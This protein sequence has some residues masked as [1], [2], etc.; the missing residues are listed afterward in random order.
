MYQIHVPSPVFLVV[1]ILWARDGNP[2]R[3]TEISRMMGKREEKACF[4][5]MPTLNHL[6]AIPPTRIIFGRE[7]TS[8]C[9][10][11]SLGDRQKNL[12]L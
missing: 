11:V 12:L 5:V 4:L 9:E 2:S 7:V 10:T 3:Q 8:V 1:L 6:L